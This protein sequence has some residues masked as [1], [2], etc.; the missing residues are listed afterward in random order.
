MAGI[1]YQS[2]F[3]VLLLIGCSVGNWSFRQSLNK[4]GKHIFAI[5]CTLF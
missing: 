1:H 2:F 4:V 3:F 5:I